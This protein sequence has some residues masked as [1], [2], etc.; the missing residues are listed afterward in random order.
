[1]KKLLIAIQV[2]W[3]KTKG[4]G[5]VYLAIAIG[6]VMPLLGFIT[7]FFQDHNTDAATLKYPVI[8][9]AVQD[10]LKGFVMFF[11]FVVYY[12]FSKQNCPD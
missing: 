7:D 6:A 8:E 12:Y 3:L 9:T 5:L 1:M 11:L 4:L 10:S 2:E